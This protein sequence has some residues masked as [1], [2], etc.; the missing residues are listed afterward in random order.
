LKCLKREVSFFQKKKENETPFEMPPK[1]KK[2]ESKFETSWKCH[3]DETCSE[4]PKWN[5]KKKRESLVRKRNKNKKTKKW[6][7]NK[8]KGNETHPEML[9][10]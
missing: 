8:K 3:W 1:G 7:E 2:D 5:L 10:K 9:L 4:M 6:N